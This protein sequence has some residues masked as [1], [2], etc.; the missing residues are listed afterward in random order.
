MFTSKV[1][2]VSLREYNWNF[3]LDAVR[4]YMAAERASIYVGSKSDLFW[5]ILHLNSPCNRKRITLMFM[6]STRDQFMIS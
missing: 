2:F 5:G 3:K 1:F 6:I 4:I